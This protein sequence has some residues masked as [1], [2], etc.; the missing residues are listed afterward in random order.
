MVEEESEGKIIVGL[1]GEALRPPGKGTTFTQIN[2]IAIQVYLDSRPLVVIH[3]RSSLVVRWDIQRREKWSRGTRNLHP[4]ADQIWL[5]LGLDWGGGFLSIRWN[6]DTTHPGIPFCS[7]WLSISLCPCHCHFQATWSSSCF[8]SVRGCINYARPFSVVGGRMPMARGRRLGKKVSPA[9]R[10]HGGWVKV[11]GPVWHPT[12]DHDLA[13]TS[14]VCGPDSVQEVQVGVYHSSPV[15]NSPRD[16]VAALG[17]LEQGSL[18][19]CPPTPREWHTHWDDT[20]IYQCRRQPP[21]LSLPGQGV[22]WG[23]LIFLCHHMYSCVPCPSGH[24]AVMSPLPQYI[25]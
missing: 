4:R 18:L 24:K 21:G 19:V 11:W 6:P 16:K 10:V 9:S 23:T 22:P 5:G 12:R 20:P 8:F 14:H 13:R 3:I 2:S 25:F 17:T 1:S 15:P 7:V